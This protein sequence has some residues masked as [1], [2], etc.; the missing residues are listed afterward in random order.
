MS[1]IVANLGVDPDIWGSVPGM[2]L[3]LGALLVIPL[4]D[5]HTVEPGGWAAAFNLRTRGWAF[6]AIAVFW[7]ILIGGLVANAITEAG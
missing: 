4:I 7:L 2:V 3:M 6:L 5:R 1:V